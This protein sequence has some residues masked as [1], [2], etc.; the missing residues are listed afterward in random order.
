MGGDRSAEVAVSGSQGMVDIGGGVG[1]KAETRCESCSAEV[2]VLR[3]LG[4]G[5][6]WWVGNMIG[7]RAESMCCRW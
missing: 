6:I 4:L 7:V 5:Y 3:E 2:G 1:V